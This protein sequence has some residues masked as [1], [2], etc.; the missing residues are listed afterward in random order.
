MGKDMVDLGNES[1]DATD[2]IL[3]SELLNRVIPTKDVSVVNEKV[4]SST[5][6]TTR[7]HLASLS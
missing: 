6:H 4:P 5:R 7:Q 3:R 2:A 1:I